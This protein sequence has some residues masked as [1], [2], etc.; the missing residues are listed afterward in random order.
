[1][2]ER[3]VMKQ[4]IYAV[5]GIA[6]VGG[7]IGLYA[8]RQPG[9]A[10]PPAQTV[11]ESNPGDAAVARKLPPRTVE[12]AGETSS[13]GPVDA[14]PAP[15]VA[16]AAPEATSPAAKEIKQLVDTLVS[17]QVSFA[18]KQAA[19]KQLKDSGQLD[20][21]ISELEQR[22]AGDPKIAEYP[23]ALGQ[24]YLQKAST[25][26]DIPDQGI[27]AMKADKSF[28]AALSLDP[29]NWEARFTKAVAMSYWPP[30]LNKGQ[31]VI[32]HFT[33]LIEQQEAKAPQPQ[34]AATYLMLGD[35]YQK[36]GKGD[37]ARATWQCG[38]ALFPGNPEL[39][40]KLQ[41]E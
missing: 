17:R 31:E 21:A 27:L 16:E 15:V 29:S 11:S 2:K 18:Q 6:A 1:M 30:Q 12:L 22:A 38:A 10:V 40:A 8:S 26:Q 5:L 39:R 41:A 28:D 37:Y 32:D 13:A 35:H 23:A 33:Q 36:T 4:L 24:A 9:P 3:T 7:G 19:W 34:F 14:K 20:Q 25:I